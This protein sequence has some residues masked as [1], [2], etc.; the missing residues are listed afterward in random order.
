MAMCSHCGREAPIVY[1]GVVPYCTACGALRAPLSTPSLNMAGKPSKMGGAVASV[2]GGLVLLVGLSMALGIGLL[3]GAIFTAAVGLAVALPVAAISAGIGGVLLRGGSSLRRAGADTERSTRDQALLS[4]AAHH[5]PL[6]AVDAARYLNVTVAAADAMLT[7]LAKRDPYRLGID[8]DD[9]GIVWYRIARPL[10]DVDALGS[11][12][13][14]DRLRVDG[15][16]RTESAVARD[17][18][19][20]AEELETEDP[21]R[22]VRR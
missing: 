11:D 20:G 15:S 13:P 9:Q 16:E 19:A 2:A 7:G 12:D 4:M 21:A 5:G 10:L 6:T 14:G 17:A 1:R 22:Q 3:L 8:V 18:D